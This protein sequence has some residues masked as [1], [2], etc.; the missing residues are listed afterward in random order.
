[1]TLHRHCIIISD[2]FSR[3]LNEGHFFLVFS[4]VSTGAFLGHDLFC[5][6]GGLLVFPQVRIKGGSQLWMRMGEIWREAFFFTASVLKWYL[7]VYLIAGK[8]EACAYEHGHPSPTSSTYNA[9]CFSVGRSTVHGLA[10]LVRAEVEVEGL[11]ST[12][13]W[14]LA[15]V[16]LVCFVLNWLLVVSIRGA[17]EVLAITLTKP[18]VFATAGERGMMEAMEQKDSEL[19]RHLG[20]YD[21]EDLSNSTRERRGFIF[22]LSDPGTYQKN[23]Q[24]QFHS[25]RCCFYVPT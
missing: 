13:L 19:L 4:G 16:L 6:N 17:A 12:I 10:G 24:P 1:M 7:V 3:C 15:H 8:F 14:T 22:Q 2:S 18:M 25:F 20:Y 21:F 11:S 9:K 23:V 5:A